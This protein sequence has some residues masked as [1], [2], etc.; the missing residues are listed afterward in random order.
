MW[1]GKGI[2]LIIDKICNGYNGYLAILPSSWQIMISLNLE[3]N[4][5][6]ILLQ[7]FTS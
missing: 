1:L 3:N 4:C 6:I 5:Q 7:K 2:N